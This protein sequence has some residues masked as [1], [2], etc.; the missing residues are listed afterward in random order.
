MR[1]WRGKAVVVLSVVLLALFAGSTAPASSDAIP[2]KQW[3]ANFCDS[4]ASWISL[5]QTRTAVY[6]KAIGAWKANGH[7]K[8]KKIRS[9]LIVY[10]NDT[11]KLTDTMISKVK[12]AGPP[13]VP[14]GAKTQAQVNSGLAQVGAVF[15]TALTQAKALPTSNA[16]RFAQKAQALAATISTG[17]QAIGPTFTA[18]GKTASPALTR[19]ARATPACQKL[20]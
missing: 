7:G 12:A 1:A 19:A 6:D 18:I 14:N 10:V 4:V 5:I 16:I 17:V 2:A 8:I 15:H 20:G 3:A 13:A 9:V 11:T